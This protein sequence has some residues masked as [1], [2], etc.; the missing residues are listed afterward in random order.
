M[1]SAVITMADQQELKSAGISPDELILRLTA[2]SVAIGVAI[3]DYE[4]VGSV[5]GLVEL[6]PAV[7]VFPVD[8]EHGQV[9]GELS[10][11]FRRR[12]DLGD[13]VGVEDLVRDVRDLLSVALCRMGRVRPVSQFHDRPSMVSAEVGPSASDAS[14]GGASD[15]LGRPTSFKAGQAV[16]KGQ[17]GLV[18]ILEAVSLAWRCLQDAIDANHD[19]KVR[20]L[21]NM[22][23]DQL[24]YCRD[25]IQEEI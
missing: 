22:L 3:A 18:E 4:D 11:L 15:G 25:A 1:G 9:L 19:D 20:G 21:L 23:E 16:V 24:L 2:L 8:E 7:Q 10:D 14:I 13:V 17:A 5:A 6:L 12:V